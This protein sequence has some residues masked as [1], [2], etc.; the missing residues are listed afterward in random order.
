MADE[1]YIR[2]SIN[3]PASQVVKGF[4]PVMPVY[5]GQLS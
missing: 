4:M 3:N 1:N 5:K 2:D